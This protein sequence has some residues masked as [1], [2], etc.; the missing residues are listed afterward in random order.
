[1]EIGDDDADRIV[2]VSDLI[3]FVEGHPSYEVA[4]R[5]GLPGSS[6]ITTGFL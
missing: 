1:L 5:Q 3:G 4:I 2:A 6:R